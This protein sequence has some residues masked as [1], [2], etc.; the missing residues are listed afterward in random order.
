MRQD[1]F[2]RWLEQQG[3][4]KSSIGTYLSDAKR[5]EGHYG[6]LDELYERDEL[7]S[8]LAEL[9]YTKEDERRGLANASKIPIDAP[10]PYHG[11][12]GYK[13]V[14]TK[15]C[16]FRK[17][18]HSE[19]A[20]THRW[21]QY[22]EAAKHRIEE[23]TLDSDEGYKDGLASALAAVRAG[24]MA[25]DE[26]WSTLLSGA[27]RDGE[28]NLI[29]WRNKA[30]INEWIEQ[31]RATVEGAL[32]EMWSQ[33]GGKSPVDRVKLF[34]DKLPERVFSKGSSTARL[35][36]ASYL[37]M[38]IPDEKLPP[39]KLTVFDRTYVQL[40]Y[41]PSDS[42]DDVALRYGHAISFLDRLIAEAGKRGMERP[43]TRL[44]AQSVV[45][46]LQN[47]KW[48]TDEEV[49][50]QPRSS[51]ERKSQEGALNTILYGPPGTG[52]T[53]KTV[54]RCVTICDGH[55][56]DKRED[57]RL[58]YEKLMAE[59]RV[60]FVTFHQSY[61]Y[62]EFVEG[63]RPAEQDGQVVYRVEP[64][65]LIRLAEKARKT[66]RL[67]APVTVPGAASLVTGDSALPH[68]DGAVRIARYALRGPYQPKPKPDSIIECVYRTLDETGQ[69]LTGEDV[70][71]RVN[72][73]VRPQT[74][75]KMTES[76]IAQTLRWLVQQERL[77][78][79]APGFSVEAA[80]AATTESTAMRGERPNFVLVID[81]I[82]RANISKVMGE[83]ITVLEEDKREGAE[84]EVT[85]TLPYSRDPFTL[86]SN[87][88]ILGTMNTADRSIALLDTALRRRFDFEEMAPDPGLL[89]DA[90]ERTG[91]DLPRVLD[92]MNKR[93]EYLVDRDHLIGHAW[94]MSAKDRPDLDSLMRRKIIPL[95]AE[96]FYDDWQKVRAVL[97]GTDDFIERVALEVPPGIDS[98]I[99][100][101]R[102][103]W[104]V[105][106]TFAEDAYERLVR[107]SGAEAATG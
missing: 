80:D 47:T 54:E 49:N 88:H 3:L 67:V 60:D 7:R 79:V 34:D 93:L 33:G 35:D 104:S 97:G 85:V 42:E 77:H 106:P 40:G 43:G 41:P 72:G 5:V 73:F 8:V 87:L 53:Y 95:I 52:K 64:G 68:I 96:Y 107:E 6:D 1:D 44:D 101:G 9:N 32:A 21:D 29:G 23:G 17:A 16:E 51:M 55:V 39:I 28:N 84:N 78:V 2:R 70:V 37:L 31:D 105:R 45:W 61:G 99:A 65:I 13:A 30:T 20:A 63:I 56:P 59:G 27:V 103:R 12:Q 26:N 14:V 4:N 94:L 86:P 48:W 102:Y 89:E 38:A 10:S 50:G 24:L 19:R 100:E 91:V 98:D 82:N 90:T 75:E 92:S 11:L 62:E 22:L 58:R 74:G 81:E 66:L 83:L 46:S 25:G 76:E 71:A 69:P 57:L 36:L 15:F 18:E